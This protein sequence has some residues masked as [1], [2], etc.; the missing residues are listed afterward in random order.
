M[1]MEEF[2]TKFIVDMKMNTKEVVAYITKLEDIIKEKDI[3]MEALE[4]YK[5]MYEGLE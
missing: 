1:T 2:T 5:F 4:G 3:E